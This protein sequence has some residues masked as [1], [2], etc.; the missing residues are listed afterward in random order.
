MKFR[1]CWTDF[2]HSDVRP[3]FIRYC[4]QWTLPWFRFTTIKIRHG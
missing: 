3:V 2:S 1:D 4:L